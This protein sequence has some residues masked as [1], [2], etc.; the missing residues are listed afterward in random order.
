MN[1]GVAIRRLIQDTIDSENLADYAI[2]IV[3]GIEPLKIKLTGMEEELF[4]ECLYETEG[5]LEKTID[6]VEHE[7]KYFDSDTGEGASGSSNR[8]TETELP[9]IQC[10]LK[11]EPLG[12]SKDNKIIINKGLEVGDKVIMLK[13]RH[14]QVYIILSKLYS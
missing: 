12:Y 8:E 11:G 2:G 3:S 14:G 6:K 5:V 9:N 7:H 10:Y 13:V 4:G 1:T